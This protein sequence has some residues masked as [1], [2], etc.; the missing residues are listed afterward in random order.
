MIVTRGIGKPYTLL[1]T[2]GIGK[3]LTEF[4]PKIIADIADLYLEKDSDLIFILS[5]LYSETTITEE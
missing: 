2:F 3:V 5:P 4:I 1:T